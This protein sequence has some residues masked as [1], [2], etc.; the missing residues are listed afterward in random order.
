MPDSDDPV[1][2]ALIFLAIQSL[3]FLLF[4]DKMSNHDDK[5]IIKPLKE[6][7]VAGKN[8]YN[9]EKGPGS[10]PEQELTEN[11]GGENQRN[12]DTNET[13]GSAINK[14]KDIMGNDR[15]GNPVT[16]QARANQ[17][18]PKGSNTSGKESETDAGQWIFLDSVPDFMKCKICSNVFESPQLLSCC[19]TNICKKC[20]ERHVQR[21]AELA[22]QK[23]SCPFCRSTDY[24]LYNNKALEKPIDQLKVKCYYQHKG[25]RWTG[26]LLDGK[27]HLRECDFV[28][29]G[30]PN[31]CGCDPLERCKLSDHMLICPHTHA[32]CSFEAIGCNMRMPL[33]RQAAQKHAC[34]YLSQHLLLVARKNIQLLKDYRSFYA[35]LQSESYVSVDHEELVR[36]QKEALASTRHTIISLKDSLQE[37]R[38]KTTSLKTELQR[39]EICSAELKRKVTLTKDTEATYKESVADIQNLPGLVPKAIGMSCP[40]VT[41]TIDNFMERKKRNDMWLSPPFYTHVGGYKMCLSVYPNGHVNDRGQ[42]VTVTVPVSIHFLMGEFDDHLMWPFPG[43]MFTIT[44]INQDAKKCNTSIHLELAGKDTLHVRSK[45]INGSLGY[46]FGVPNLL[47]CSDLTAFLRRDNSFKLMVYRIQFLPL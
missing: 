1:D 14:S 46:G 31:G 3:Q 37:I 17:N 4:I 16:G 36:S 28:P 44:A 33:P 30:C 5:P 41:F 19:G 2:T 43:A 18:P 29:V 8:R 38:Q 21:I 26:V 10:R 25:C 27:L 9:S 32:A 42:S 24:V 23:P 7:P 45:Q 34:D 47:L 40:P 15:E 11:N 22:D 39:E 20:M 35:S 13:G 6:I 12:S